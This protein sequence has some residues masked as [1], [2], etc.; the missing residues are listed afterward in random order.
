MENIETIYQKL[1]PSSYCV[2]SRS[3]NIYMKFLVDLVK[4]YLDDS[5]KMYHI[6]ICA[7]NTK[8]IPTYLKFIPIN[9][10]RIHYVT[11]GIIP[12]N[13][14]ANTNNI[15][16]YHNKRVPQKNVQF[17]LLDF[18]KDKQ[19]I[20]YIFVGKPQL[21][22]PVVRIKLFQYYLHF[23]TC[24]YSFRRFRTTEIVNNK[25]KTIVL[26]KYRSQ[27]SKKRK[28]KKPFWVYDYFVIHDITMDISNY[29]EF[30]KRI[31]KPKK[32]IEPKKE[33]NKEKE[34][35]DNQVELVYTS[36]HSD[37][38]SLIMPDGSKERFNEIITKYNNEA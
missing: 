36:I 26:S 23:E 35:I 8:Y 10:S 12:N 7:N 22:L 5:E 19:N 27:Q 30:N 21:L 6:Y 28:A 24:S 34:I 3:I 2:Y 15:Y 38:V 4:K 1:I 17:A 9:N 33:E 37:P 20:K 32:P 29:V 13:L 16:I 18:M 11:T 14:P 25:I 31:Y